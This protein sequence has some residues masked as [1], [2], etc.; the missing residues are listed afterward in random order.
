MPHDSKGNPVKAGD[1]VIFHAI[2]K[3]VFQGETACNANFSFADVASTGEYTPNVTCNTRLC[4]VTASAP[5]L[6]ALPLSEDVPV[7]HV[8]PHPDSEP[9][10]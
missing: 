6:V 2:V 4:E 1:N 8:P 10:A 9:V 3:E 5:D 7:A